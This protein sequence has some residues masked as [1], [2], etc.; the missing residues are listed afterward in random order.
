MTL[1]TTFQTVVEF[2]KRNKW[3]FQAVEN[4]PILSANFRG[5]NGSYRL[6]VSVDES[7]DLVQVF[8]FVP[9]VV[10]PHKLAAVSELCIRISHNMK[11]GRFEL[12][13]ADGELRFQTYGTYPAR[14]LKEEVLRRVFGVNLAMTDQHFP[15]FIAVIYSDV[16]PDQAAIDVRIRA[17]QGQPVG[18]PP[19][20][21]PPRFKLN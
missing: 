10:P 20:I 2:F 4:R 3:T 1:P 11:L 6:L 19:I 15:A 13:H 18:P 16:I 7:D 9:V 21:T 17:S 14:D 8:C 5:R 12:N